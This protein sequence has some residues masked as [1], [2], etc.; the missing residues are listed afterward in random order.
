M[1]SAAEILGET[2]EQQWLAGLRLGD[3]A[4]FE[5][6]FRTYQ[7]D[8]F[9]WILRIVRDRGVAEDLTIETFFR[10]H[11]AHARFDAERGFG[12]WARRIATHAAVDWMR[13]QRPEHGMPDEFFAAVPGRAEADPLVTEDIRREVA[14]ALTQ[15]P[16]KLRVVAVLAVIE[17]R[18]QKEIAEALGITVS[19]VKLRQFRAMRRL[20]SHLEEKGITP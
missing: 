4:A 20:R 8:V 12:P 5:A 7:R 2:G 11:R 18:P 1:M 13:R 17:E 16:P 19:A 10:I 9:G 15:L 3:E 14:L 6:L